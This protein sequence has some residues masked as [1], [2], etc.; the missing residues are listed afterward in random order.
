MTQQNAELLVS[1]GSGDQRRYDLAGDGWQ[2]QFSSTHITWPLDLPIQLSLS[3]QGPDGNGTFTGTAIRSQT[4]E[5]GTLL[6]VTL[7]SIAATPQE[8]KTTL[9]LLLPDVHTTRSPEW[10]IDIRTLAILTT[11]IGMTT[12]RQAPTGQIQTYQVYKLEGTVTFTILPDHVTLSVDAP[13]YYIGDPINVTV[14]NRSTQGISFTN[15]QS[16]CSVIQLQRQEDGTWKEVSPCHGIRDP[17]AYHLEAG[18]DLMVKL[19]SSSESAGLY[20]AT[21][22]Y[23]TPE[24][25]E[26]LTIYSQEFQVIAKPE[27]H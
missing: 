18:K 2:I 26:P 10:S 17:L 24:A 19:I 25:T 22:S 5:L 16:E 7:P 4:S 21:L 14:S 3:Y 9:T 8:E 23:S 27:G 15:L 12:D 11:S 1:P 6:T 13:P 20:R